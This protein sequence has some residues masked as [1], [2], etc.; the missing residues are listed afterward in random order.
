MFSK[1]GQTK[2]NLQQNVCFFG[3][4]LLKIW[5]MNFREDHR[6]NPYI[7]CRVYRI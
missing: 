6:D 1:R 2:G 3:T 7:G 4:F 5:D